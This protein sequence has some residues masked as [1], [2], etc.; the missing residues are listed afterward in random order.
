[1]PDAEQPADDRP[2]LFEPMGA[3]AALV[4]TR[5]RA[6]LAIATIYTV[7]ASSI[8]DA[9]HAGDRAEAW[10]RA[11]D[12]TGTVES[13][14]QVQ[15]DGGTL[16]WLG[17]ACIAASAVALV[18]WSSGILR[19]AT[20]RGVRGVHRAEAFSWFIPLVGIGRAIRP[21]QISVRW[22]GYSEHRLTRW[23]WVAYIHLFVA[24]FITLGLLRSQVVAT[25]S[26]SAVLDSLATQSTIRWVLAAW[27]VCSA[28]VAMLAI[29]H[30]DRSL[31][32]I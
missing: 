6:W 12:G 3:G 19:N 2:L 14:L 21:L 16:R 9:V 8:A 32:K 25:D 22:V 10:R 11:V 4:A 31:S 24:M 15:H 5:V 1:V 18:F 17:W 23:L 28:T 20:A 27:I 29:R 13:A 7:A 26:D 30:T